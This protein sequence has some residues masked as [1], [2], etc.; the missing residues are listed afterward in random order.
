[1]TTLVLFGDDLRIDDNPALAAAA[2]D[3]DGLIALFVLDEVSE[4]VRPLGGAARWW[5]HGS[6][7]RLREAL[8]E[9]EIPLALATRCGCGGG[10]RGRRPGRSH[11]GALESSL[12]R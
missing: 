5:L 9:R 2:D 3:P 4:G 7:E 10:S 1:M 8:A 11:P 6:L 12:R